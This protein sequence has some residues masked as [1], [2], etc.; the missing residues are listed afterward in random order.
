MLR[1]RDEADLAEIIATTSCALEPV[2][3]GSLRDIGK[4]VEG[5]I[6]DLSALHGIVSYEPD[7]LV[8]TARAATPLESIERALSEHRQ[9]LAFEPVDWTPLLGSAGGRTI[10]GVL[11]A[12][13]SGSR[14]IVAGAARDHFLGFRAVSVRGER[15]KGG[16]R[17]VKNV[18]GYD[19]PK[20]LAGSWGTLAVL[21]E[22]TVRVNPAPEHER[23]LIVPAGGAAE[24]VQSM[25]N[26]LGSACDV[27]A[28]AFV[29][30]R[31]VALRLEGFLP[32]VSARGAA[33]LERLAPAESVWLEG[34]ASRGFWRAVGAAQ[35]L[36]AHPIIW[37]LSVPPGDAPDIIER[38]AP[39][40]YLL[41]W[42]GGRIWIGAA[43]A[44]AERVRGALRAGHALLFKAPRAVRASTAVFQPLSGP[45][46]A[47]TARV[48]AAF[49]PA[50]RLNPGR[51][52]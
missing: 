13:V 46:A 3:G 51:M 32:S 26:A 4:P 50:A 23:T 42:G 44:E 6:L 25:A 29:P 30:R 22:V 14:R 33:L 5:E 1:P 21:T 40:D 24:A 20:L 18:T 49:D 27:S 11:A 48:K 10:G 9:R 19:L 31:G 36:G 12:N 47:L 37:R 52:G 2:A 41:D 17:V 35:P 7:E 34:E 16:G 15:F 28:A 8:L 38:L 43:H 39:A 45:L